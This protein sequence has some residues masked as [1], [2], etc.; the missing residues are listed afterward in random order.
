MVVDS[1]CQGLLGMVLT[2]HVLI[3]VLSD[4]VGCRQGIIALFLGKLS[5]FFLNN[6]GTKVN[7][8]I[9]NKY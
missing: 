1:Y 6:V 8:L 3:K 7:A 4:L 5:N 9:A 2:N